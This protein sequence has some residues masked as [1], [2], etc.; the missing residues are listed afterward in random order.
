[1]TMQAFSINGGTQH[2]LIRGRADAPVLLLVQAG[3]GFPMIH[4]ADALERRLHLERAFRVVY[5]DQRG[6]GLSFD[7]SQTEPLSLDA[8]V[9]DVAVM[10]AA[11]CERLGVPHLDVAGFSLGGSL[12]MLAA[13]RPGAACDGF[14]RWDRTSRWPRARPSRG[15]SRATKPSGAGIDA[16]SESSSALV[17]RPMTPPNAS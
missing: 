17:L 10:A 2:A 11:T 15:S 14:S 7:P 5:W 12:A 9:D 8:L 6:T 13:A 3:P 4:E 1:M 16:R